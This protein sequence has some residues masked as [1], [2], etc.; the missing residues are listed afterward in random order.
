MRRLTSK[1]RRVP[2]LLAAARANIDD[3]PRVFLA[4]G[5]AMMRGAAEI[6]AT[7]LPQAFDAVKDEQL[8][9]EMRTAAR[10]ARHAIEEYARDLEARV[11]TAHGEFAIGAASLAARYHAEE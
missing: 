4:R 10:D 9:R 8:H 6:L 11:P 2:R 7:D 3:P 1:L 5:I